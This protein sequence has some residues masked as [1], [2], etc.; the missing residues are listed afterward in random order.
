MNRTNKILVWVIILLALLNITTIG[1]ILYHNQRDKK[2]AESIV[3]DQGRNPLNGRF[4]RQKL[5]FDDQQM[6]AFRTAN[7]EFQPKAKEV[8]YVL[9]SLKKQIFFEINKEKV[10]TLKL[11]QLTESIG[12]S[13]A[14]L[15][16]ITNDFYLQVKDIC[17]EGQCEQLKDAFEPL[18]NDQ[19]NTGCCKE[20]GT[21]CRPGS[22]RGYGA[23][24][25][26]NSNNNN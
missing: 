8:I 20:R 6:E 15:K 16:K 21:L 24:L 17:D 22:E 25:N 10:D 19:V 13:H 4:F 7:R 26:R 2:V 18:Y 11:R 3:F 5:G 12:S 9:D 14:E 1:T 23:E